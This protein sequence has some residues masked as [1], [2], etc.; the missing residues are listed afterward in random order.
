MEGDAKF[1]DVQDDLRS[2]V[3]QQLFDSMGIMPIIMLWPWVLRTLPWIQFPSFCTM[4][5][6]QEWIMQIVREHT[7]CFSVTG[8][9]T[10][11]KP[12]ITYLSQQTETTLQSLQCQT[13]PSKR[14]IEEKDHHLDK[15]STRE[16]DIA[17]VYEP[18]YNDSLVTNQVE[19]SESAHNRHD[20]SSILNHEDPLA[21]NHLEASE[22]AHNRYGLSSI[23]NH[24][25]PLAL[26][27][28][29]GAHRR[30]KWMVNEVDSL[31][32][33]HTRY[34]LSSILDYENPSAMNHLETSSRRHS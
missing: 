2:L 19:T 15:R 24:E 27:T 26:K 23:I 20:L 1:Q 4:A 34:D 6:S 7:D 5:K 31:D 16:P 14:S 10:T 25:D 28:S 32:S 21:T 11:Q 17:S 30:Y 22:S 3:C 12:T 9:Q 18:A 8:Y 13:H 29:G 33:A